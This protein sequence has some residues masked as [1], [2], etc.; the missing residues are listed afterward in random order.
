MID[1]RKPFDEIAVRNG[2]P[3]RLAIDGSASLLE[4]SVFYLAFTVVH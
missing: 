2:S 3:H 4:R 1:I